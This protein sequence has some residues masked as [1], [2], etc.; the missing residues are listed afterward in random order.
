MQLL[1]PSNLTNLLS[2][3]KGASVTETVALSYWRNGR[4]HLHSR[5]GVM[6]SPHLVSS[7]FNY[8]KYLHTSPHL[9]HNFGHL[10]PGFGL[11]DE[12]FQSFLTRCKS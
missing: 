12:C 5:V 7:R 11:E 10:S 9:V 8:W 6:G 2:K 4:E 3:T 1:L